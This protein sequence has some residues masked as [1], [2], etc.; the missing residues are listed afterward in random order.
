MNDLHSHKYRISRVRRIVRGTRRVAL[1]LC[2]IAF[3]VSMAGVLSVNRSP[4][5]MFAEGPALISVR[6]IVGYR[7]IHRTDVAPPS[8]AWSIQFVSF[9]GEQQ[10]Q[11]RS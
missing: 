11:L 5:G 1:G 4:G 10:E 6:G 2:L 9:F 7:D 8:Q 3:L